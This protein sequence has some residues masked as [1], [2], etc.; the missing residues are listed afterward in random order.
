MPVEQGV[1]VALAVA[2]PHLAV[3]RERGLDAANLHHPRDRLPL[4]PPACAI[5]AR[6]D[7]VG[8]RPH[9]G[10]GRQARVER[11]AIRSAQGRPVEI[12]MSPPMSVRASPVITTR[13]LSMTDRSVTMAATPSARQ[14][15]KNSRRFQ[16][17]RVSR[18]AMRRMNLIR[19]SAGAG[20]E[21]SAIGPPVLQAPAASAGERPGWHRASPAPA[22]SVARG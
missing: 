14:T 22:S 5:V 7:G 21:R 13:T 15:K 8:A 4:D 19:G 12:R 1:A 6:L 20:L 11:R 17:A 18:S 9:A 2:Q 16:A 10:L 3:Q